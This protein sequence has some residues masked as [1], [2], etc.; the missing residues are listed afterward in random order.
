MTTTQ[1]APT[2]VNAIRDMRWIIGLD[3]AFHGY[4][5]VKPI[6]TDASCFCL[7]LWDV[8]CQTDGEEI[9]MGRDL[10]DSEAT[11]LVNHLNLAIVNGEEV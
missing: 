4:C 1:T 5:T 9:L 8:Y 3:A 6:E 7:P 2:I 11:V 10:T